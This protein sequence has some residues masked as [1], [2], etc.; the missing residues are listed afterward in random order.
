MKSS[1]SSMAYSKR[2]QNQT[3]KLTGVPLKQYI[4]KIENTHAKEFAFSD[5]ELP[6][7]FLM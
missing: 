4:S 1:N 7:D 3:P 2:S 5:Y 6:Q